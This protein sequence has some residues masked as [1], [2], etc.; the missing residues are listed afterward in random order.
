M[1]IGPGNTGGRDDFVHLVLEVSSINDRTNENPESRRG[2]GMLTLIDVHI[3]VVIL[4]C[5]VA[6][7]DDSRLLS[8]SRGYGD[9]IDRAK[10]KRINFQIETLS[11]NLGDTSTTWH[12]TQESVPASPKSSRSSW[13][14]VELTA[15]DVPV[16]FESHWL[17]KAMPAGITRRDRSPDMCTVCTCSWITSTFPGETKALTLNT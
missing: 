3:V 7:C 10:W 17:T 12:L 11:L 16:L 13:K 1:N 4:L 15:D 14:S 6:P 8:V 9:V 2:G 5:V